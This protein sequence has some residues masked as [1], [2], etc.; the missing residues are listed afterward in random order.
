MHNNALLKNE[1]HQLYIIFHIYLNW[2]WH[3]NSSCFFDSFQTLK[4]AFKHNISLHKNIILNIKILF[5][6]FF[7]I[8]E[9]LPC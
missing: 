5:I 6:K 4:F 2:V 7:G 1:I 8:Y 3:F 9:L